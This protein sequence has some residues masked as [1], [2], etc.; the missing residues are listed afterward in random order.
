MRLSRFQLIRLEPGHRLG[1]R[2]FEHLLLLS[3]CCVWNGAATE[4]R[5]RI[6][7]VGIEPFALWPNQTVDYVVQMRLDP[8]NL[9]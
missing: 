6:E 9:I 5:T 7:L 4:V 1:E 3:I 8:L 2:V